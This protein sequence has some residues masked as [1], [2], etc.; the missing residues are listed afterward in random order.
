MSGYWI[1]DPANPFNQMSYTRG[2][3]GYD[4]SSTH[5]SNAAREFAMQGSGYNALPRYADA[6]TAQSVL[7]PGSLAVV[8]NTVVKTT[9][10][11]KS[12]VG[13]GPGAPGA[14]TAGANTNGGARAPSR[15]A[16]TQLAIATPQ[17]RGAFK[18]GFDPGPLVWDFAE[19]FET[20]P[21]IGGIANK[22]LERIGVGGPQEA[23]GA[24]ADY[25]WARTNTGYVVI[26]SSDVKER[27][28]DNALL[29]LGWIWR[30]DL[31]PRFGFSDPV[32]PD[33]LDPQYTHYNQYANEWQPG[34]I[35]RYDKDGNVIRTGG[36]F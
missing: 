36:G 1:D 13:T 29:E 14:A 2:G 35:G 22:P 33:F 11:V 20:A 8:G 21:E 28:E 27:L 19:Q 26:P 32:P 5:E 18:P 10:Q 16:G 15:G 7:P 23:P 4:N 17:N 12:Q 30:N 31:S 24:I 9:A 34:G 6:A 25:G 3:G